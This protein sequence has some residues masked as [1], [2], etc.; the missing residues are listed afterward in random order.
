M[1]DLPD[2]RDLLHVAGWSAMAFRY[3]THSQALAE[4]E[5]L[6]SHGDGKVAP[7]TEAPAFEAGCTFRGQRMHLRETAAELV[8]SSDDRVRYHWRKG[9]PWAR[10][11]E[12]EFWLQ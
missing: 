2:L 10:V 5:A 1:P 4:S 6:A 9:D 8:V 11:A 12:E 7:A 3:L